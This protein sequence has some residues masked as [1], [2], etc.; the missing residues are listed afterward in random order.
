[1][2]VMNKVTG[3]RLEVDVRKSRLSRMRRRIKAWASVVD[4]VHD[5]SKNR[6]VMVLLTYDK[7][8]SQKWAKNQIRDYLR[9]LRRYIPKEKLLA[10]AWVAEHHENGGIHYHIYF[11]IK[12][13]TDFPRPDESGMWSYGW[14]TVETG[15]TAYYLISYLKKKYQKEGPY[16]KGMRIFAVW[17]K[18][19]LASKMKM[20]RFRLSALPSWL[21][22]EILK[23]YIL[24]SNLM[25]QRMEGGG[26]I[27]EI[28]P[29]RNPYGHNRIYEMIFFSPWSVVTYGVPKKKQKKRIF[30]DVQIKKKKFSAA[31]IKLI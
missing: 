10:Y 15:R 28:P 27:I 16:P 24:T 12:K 30:R 17:I 2:E 9:A 4:S 29:D 6:L 21:R 3:E 20:W 19:N 31:Q 1:M 18:K 7:G 26:W 25:P 5:K 22:E 13:G 11:L 23:A 14:S 8:N